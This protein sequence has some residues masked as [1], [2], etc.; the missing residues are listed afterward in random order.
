MD[1]HGHGNEKYQQAVLTRLERILNRLDR[2]IV[3]LKP[4]QHIPDRV[5]VR[6]TAP[7]K[8]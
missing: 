4:V 3:L 5:V 8:E 2:I 7:Q 6:F 1:K